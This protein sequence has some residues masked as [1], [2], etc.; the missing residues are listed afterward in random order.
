M[1]LMKSL[2]LIIM[3][4]GTLISISAYSWINIWI[5]LEMNLLAFIPLINYDNYKHSSETSMKYFLVQV[6]AS[7]FIMFAIPY[8]FL[9]F[10]SF[11]KLN[12]VSNFIFNCAILMKM[13][14]APFH[15]W[16]PEVVRGMSWMN[17]MLMLT[18]QKI[19]PMILIM[20][21][22][23]M[24]TLF[25]MIILVSMTVSGVKAWNQ[26]SLKK[27]LALSSINHMGWM[28]SMMFLNQ[29]LWILYFTVYLFITTNLILVLNKYNINTTYELFNLMNLNKTTK[30]FFFLN[31]FSLG[32]IPPFLGFFPKW[33]VLKILMENDLYFLA[34]LMIFLTLISLYVYMRMIFQPMTFKSPEKKN[35]F[36]NSDYFFV[37]VMNFINLAGLII[38]TLIFN[39]Y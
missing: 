30:F 10:N 2:F 28:M 6:S 3:M 31:L 7:M 39:L 1:K 36:K 32:G 11:D 17:A 4:L 27:I 35:I 24:N 18:W 12:E 21:N 29:S 13:G 34:F 26:T 14:A 38:F 9:K 37:Y 5:G 8:S 20:Y 19:A 25:Y 16:Y 15:M 33:M 22:F 23:K